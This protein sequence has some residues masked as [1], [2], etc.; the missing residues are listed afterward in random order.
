[1]FCI[2][3]GLE[4]ISRH[5]DPRIF[6]F[7]LRL[8][9]DE[10]ISSSVP[11]K[12]ANLAFGCCWGHEL[13]TPLSAAAKAQQ[14]PASMPLRSALPRFESELVVSALRSAAPRC[15]TGGDCATIF[16]EA[17]DARDHSKRQWRGPS[18]FGCG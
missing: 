2:R 7:R 14:P 6:G 12:T 1:V 3:P 18:R 17:C 16:P 10:Q 5:G 8:L 11:A 9:V 13:S 4:R 15:T